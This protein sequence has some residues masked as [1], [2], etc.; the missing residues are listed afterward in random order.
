MEHTVDRLTQALYRERL[1]NQM[2]PFV[3][4]VAL[5]NIAIGITGH[6]Q[7]FE[8][9]RALAQTVNEHRT[10][11]ARHHD[12][13]Q[14]KS[15]G[16]GE[17]FKVPYSAD[18]ILRDDHFEAFFLQDRLEKTANI[19]LVI[20]NEHGPARGFRNFACGHRLKSSLESGSGQR[21]AVLNRTAANALPGAP[22][23]DILI[24]LK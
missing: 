8:A 24:R 5:Y 3:D 13:H 6:E 18:R 7:Y 15:G 2:K 23:F 20:D 12:I 16:L 14:E 1:G 9:G 22:A 10:A 19:R 17:R 21:A 4:D 11:H